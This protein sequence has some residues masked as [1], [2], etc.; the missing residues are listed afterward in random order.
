VE[1][2]APR[3]NK[4]HAILIADDDRDVLRAARVTLA[5]H[6]ADIETTDDPHRV[7]GILSEREMDA[8]LLDMNFITGERSGREGLNVLTRI[9]EIDL[10]LSVI[11][12]TAYGGVMLAVQALKQGAVDFILKPWHNEK[13]LEAVSAGV[14]LTRTKRKM[15]TLDLD[16]VEKETIERALARHGGNISLAA[17]TL[18][19]SRAALYRRISKH[20]LDRR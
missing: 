16:Q 2:Y 1:A 17:S 12:M 6:F 14:A 9:R 8:V 11:L 5:P 13:L 3:M 4:P 19:L 10:N 7:E 18:G 15:E 20:R